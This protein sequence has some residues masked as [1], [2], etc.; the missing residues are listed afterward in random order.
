MKNSMIRLTW[1]S[2]FVDIYS[3]FEIQNILSLV[4]YAPGD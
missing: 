1:E 4:P 2:A 3:Q